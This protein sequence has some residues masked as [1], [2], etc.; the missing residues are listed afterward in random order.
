[1]PNI[2]LTTFIAAPIERVF[3]LSR[4]LTIYKVLM[5]G[6]KEKFSSGAASNLMNHGE[7]ITF[8]AKHF[9]KTRLVTTRVTDLK[10]PL[11]FV[12]EQVKGDLLHFKHEHHF[13]AVENGTI[14]ID[15]IDFEGPRDVIGK[16]MGR[17]YLKHYLEKYL[18]KRNILIQ[19]YAETEKWRAVLS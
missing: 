1:M 8:H 9:G 6:R 11:S 17:L 3:D 5:Q 2:H 4:N 7:T 12:Q 18:S 14:L 15:M 10:K 13:K 16:V 19:Q